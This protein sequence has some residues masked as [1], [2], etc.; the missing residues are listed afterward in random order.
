MNHGNGKQEI[1][2]CKM[3]KAP[4]YQTIYILTSFFD[5]A[6][7]HFSNRMRHNMPCRFSVA[8]LALLLKPQAHLLERTFCTNSFT[9]SSNAGA[10]I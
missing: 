8:W 4:L 6:F 10:F 5:L 3:L 9:A 7:N 2:Y 1:M